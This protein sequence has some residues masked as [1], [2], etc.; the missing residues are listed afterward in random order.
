MLFVKE[1][2]HKKLIGFRKRLKKVIGFY[3]MIQTLKWVEMK[4]TELLFI[5]ENKLDH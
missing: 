4:S 2:N 5:K 1:K 3:L